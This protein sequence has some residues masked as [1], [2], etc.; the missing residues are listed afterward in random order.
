MGEL[1]EALGDLDPQLEG[2]FRQGDALVARIHDPGVVYLVAQIGREL[3]RGVVRFLEGDQGTGV[4]PDR[5]A[6]ESPGAATSDSGRDLTAKNR[7]R[8]AD[9]LQLD[10][11]DPRVASWHATVGNFSNWMKFRSPGPD[12]NE[13]QDAFDR[14]SALLFGRLGPYFSTQSELDGFLALPSPTEDDYAQLQPYLVRPALRRYFFKSLR[15]PAWAT[16]L[17]AQGGF[18]NPPDIKRD[19]EDGTAIPVPW[20]EGEYLV[21]IAE[22]LPDLVA[23][24]LKSIPPDLENPVVLRCATSALLSLPTAERLELYPI[25]LRGLKTDAAPWLVDDA[26]RMACL[27]VGEDVEAAVKVVAHLMFVPDSLPE[28]RSLATGRTEWLFPRLHAH[29]HQQFFSGPLAELIQAA[30]LELYQLLR[31]KWALCKPLIE[32]ADLRGLYSPSQVDLRQPDAYGDAV[33][34]LVSSLALAACR[35]AAF[36]EQQCLA[37]LETLRS[38]DILDRR[39]RFRVLSDAGQH[40][41]AE[42]VVALGSNDAIDPPFAAREVSAFLRTR[43]HEAPVGAKQL[44]L[45]A[46][47]NGPDLETLASITRFRGIENPTREQLAEI[48][49]QWQRE[50]IRWFRGNVPGELAKLADELGEGGRAPSHEEQELA[51]VG[52]YSGGVSSH[53]PP[54]PI[55]SSTLAALPDQEVLDFLR[56]WP[57]NTDLAEHR[58][59]WDLSST[60]S[61]LATELPYKAVALLDLGLP[62]SLPAQFAASLVRGLSDAMRSGA[63]SMT[64]AA[65]VLRRAL[66][67]IPVSGWEPVG[68]SIA[69]S[70][71]A[72]LSDLASANRLSVG[73]FPDAWA[74]LDALVSAM[75]P[76]E[77][78]EDDDSLEASLMRALNGPVGRATDATVRLALSAYRAIPDDEVKAARRVAIGDE[79]AKRLDA[80]LGRGDTQA[81]EAAAIVGQYFP[82]IHLLARDWTLSVAPTLFTGGALHPGRAPGWGIYLNRGRLFES[83][84]SDIREWYLRAA[85]VA[86]RSPPAERFSVHEGLADHL[87]TATIRGLVHIDDDDDLLRIAWSRLPARALARVYWSVFRG[88]SD[89]EKAPPPDFV[90]RL[91][92]FW[93]WRLQGME[94]GDPDTK[95]EASGLAWFLRTPYVPMKDVLDLGPRTV[96]LAEGDINMLTNWDLMLEWLEVDPERT[97]EIAEVV[98]RR[99]LSVEHGIILVEDVHAVLSGILARGPK[100]LVKRVKKLVH[101]LGER[102]YGQFRDLAD[103]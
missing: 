81:P 79:L 99:Q 92:T 27:L 83:V 41:P 61:Q 93:R 36:G 87:L 86:D 91:V 49:E 59:E 90:E 74:T 12:P 14:F 57:S 80:L 3:S 46:L 64:E 63:I 2:L 88:W 17:L 50:R 18:A 71:T 77:C 70:V 28:Q 103:G 40:A 94:A 102:G 53:A 5:A 24:V 22:E 97:F 60:L 89:S 96:K 43:F 35:A 11:D 55:E 19:A 44:F 29:G 68:L 48:I 66:E 16:V 52:W 37:V 45:H 56:E 98:I 82:Q 30:P 34:H 84:F 67:L 73:D 65:P 33:E 42:V 85:R 58:A 23:T 7:D 20:P 78:V 8:I 38:D 21:R 39:M 51:E 10:R 25:L 101:E 15:G 75:P 32:S 95:E 13:V 54:S 47:S 100:A 9:I 31:T 6:D 1:A 69:A 72:A 62:T 76:A 26:A 4:E